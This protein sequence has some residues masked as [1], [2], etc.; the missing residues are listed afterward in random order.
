MYKISTTNKGIEVNYLRNF[1][2]SQLTEA[3]PFAFF[4]KMSP[5]MKSF[6]EE[7]KETTAYGEGEG[8]R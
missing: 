1:G 6:V 5:G 8:G 2:S 4:P 3:M 7:Q